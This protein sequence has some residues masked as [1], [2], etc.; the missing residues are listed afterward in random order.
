MRNETLKFCLIVFGVISLISCGNNEKQNLSEAE[1]RLLEIEHDENEFLSDTPRYKFGDEL[2]KLILSDT[3]TMSYPFQLLI[4]S[5]GVNITT[6]QDGNLRFYSWVTPFGGTMFDYGSVFQYRSDGKVFSF[7]GTPCDY[8][9]NNN[10]IQSTGYHDNGKAFLNI[11]TVKIENKT[12]YLVE[13]W[14][15]YDSQRGVGSIN[16]FTIEND[17]LK[18]ENL[19]R[20]KKDTLSTISIE[21]NF[22]NWYFSANNGQ[23]FDWIFSF[24]EKT[25]TLYVPL[26]NDDIDF[27]FVTDQYLL[28]QLKG[29]YFQYTGI[30]GG[31]WLHSSVRKFRY[32]AGIFE[33]PN[34]LV[35]VDK[36]NN[37]KYRYTSWSKNKTMADEPDLIIENGIKDDSIA[38]F[39]YIFNTKEYKY[40]VRPTAEHLIVWKND[41]R[42]LSE[43]IGIE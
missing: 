27:G 19:F 12:Y 15:R 40:E 22:A 17:R 18:A 20:T 2:T 10:F 16:V 38:N 43:K 7:A 36:M 31:H 25:N 35:R 29:N 13:D 30:N 8:D 9:E 39:G 6:S 11:H 21:Y 4:D 28:Y 41:K 32:L 23:G 5:S 26:I 3:S 1:Q 34:Y 42:I 24:D 37:N 33:T 14:S